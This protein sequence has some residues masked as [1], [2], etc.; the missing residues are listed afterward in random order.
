MKLWTIQPLEWYENLLRDGM[1]YANPM[2]IDFI[3]ED[4]FSH[5]YDWLIAE[6]EEKIGKRPEPNCYPIWAWYQW[7]DS[8]KRK[9]DLRFGGVGNKAQKSVLL[10]I[11]KADN[12]VLL[13][14]FELWHSVLNEWCITDNEQEDDLFNQALARVGVEFCD[15]YAYP[16]E[17]RQQM[18]ESWQKIFDMDYCSE[19]STQPFEKKSIQA[20]FW[21]LSL[22]EVRNVRFFTAK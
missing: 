8:R 11:E 5:A 21:R 20:T 2:Q 15:K 18:I 4:N 3:K 7:Q 9:P 6:M 22:E 16:T 17:L 13:S 14:D 10:E 19:Y 1:I 12:T